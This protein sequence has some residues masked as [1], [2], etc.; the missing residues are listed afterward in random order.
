MPILNA[1]HPLLKPAQVVRKCINID[2]EAACLGSGNASATVQ[3]TMSLD[4]AIEQYDEAAVRTELAALYGVAPG[5]IELSVVAGSLELTVTITAPS[6]A[7]TSTAASI[8]AVN[9]ASLTS[10]LG[11]AV[12]NVS[13]AHALE[14]QAASCAEGYGGP[15]CAVCAIGYFGGGEGGSCSACADAG[16][17]TVTIAIQG[18]VAFGVI[19]ILT[20]LVLKFG[21]RA[22]TT[23]ASTLENAGNDDG[24]LASITDTVQADFEE[25]AMEK[26]DKKLDEA[27]KS[28]SKSGRCVS[29][30]G[31]VGGFI[32]SFGVKI[33]ILVS[34]YQVLTGLGMTFNIPYPDT[35]TEWLSKI[36]AIE[37][38][39]EKQA[40]SHL[41][42][43]HTAFSTP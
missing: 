37:L 26:M 43:L 27:D 42:A 12:L 33:K 29:F 4:M 17:P 14:P 22:L 1:T 41:P 20:L 13:S 9:S 40:P 19:V 25:R 30:L 39:S 23:V 15:Y 32:S 10:S 2:A 31:K 16:D 18:G 28:K 36:S 24:A 3:Q 11:R 21:K 38:D 7:L 8:N 34:L 35:Y 5:Q 6:T